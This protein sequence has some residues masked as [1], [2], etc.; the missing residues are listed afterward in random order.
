M[1]TELLTRR[2]RA[3]RNVLIALAI[4]SVTFTA[5]NAAYAQATSLV[6]D[7]NGDGTDDV[8]V[9]APMAGGIHRR[10]VVSVFFGVPGIG[11][12]ATLKRPDLV[13]MGGFDNEGY[14]S[15]LA[16]ADFDR[17][18]R[19]EL[20]VGAPLYGGNSGRVEILEF[21]S[22]GG[23]PYTRTRARLIQ[24][25]TLRDRPE[26][27]D[28]FGYALTTGDFDGNGYPDL[29]IGVPFE[30]LELETGTLVN[31]GAVQV[32][33]S[34]VAGFNVSN[35]YWSQY[36][37]G[38]LDDPE[39]NDQFGSALA[40][41]DFT[42][43]GIDDLAVGVPYEDDALTNQGA[44]NV[45]F[46][47]P[48]GLSSKG[49]H[50]LKFVGTPILAGEH[51]DARLGWALAAGDING[52]GF[53][54]LAIGAPYALSG[55]GFVALSFGASGGLGALFMH[56]QQIVDLAD[57]G[58]LLGYS[59]AVADFNGDGFADVA[60]GA[61]GEDVLGVVD[62]GAVTVFYG[63]NSFALTRQEFWHQNT[64]GVDDKIE[65][66][67]F[68]GQSLTTGDYNA[69]GL[70]DLVIGVGYEDIGSIIN[71]GVTHVI[72]GAS[73]GLNSKNDFLLWAASNET[74]ALFGYGLRR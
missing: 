25:S 6:A 74:R 27:G 31:V 53:A 35:Q 69:D 8:A 39:H 49:D 45:I 48:T 13:R 64:Y 30:D 66:A 52:D 2:E 40:A 4:A 62:A 21:R 47:T 20:A 34:S 68:F 11:F 70:A 24:G 56:W 51:F 10:G 22:S 41:A 26:A 5:A 63:R 28:L 59:V 16:A 7:F 9:G 60:A 72:P 43:D 15:A 29:A 73:T 19:F 36:E 71:A 42:G 57:P 54:D 46:G 67:D 3:S 37:G 14:G 23:F 55:T 12:T 61:I 17:D 33:Y 18:G 58:D 38:I 65:P 44:V 1:L 50:F 32:V